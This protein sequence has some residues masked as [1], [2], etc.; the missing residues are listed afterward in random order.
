MIKIQQ[1]PG[2]DWEETN[3]IHSGS[4]G[5]LHLNP[6]YCFPLSEGLFQSPEFS[7]FAVGSLNY[8]CYLTPKTSNIFYLK[9]FF[10]LEYDCFPLLCWFLLYNSVSQLCGH[11]CPLFSS[12]PPTPH[13]TPLGRRGALSWAPCATQPPSASVC[14]THVVYMSMLVSRSVPPPRV[15]NCLCLHLYSRPANRL[16]NTIFLDPICMH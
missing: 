15:H 7:S 12:L 14:V 11:I 13:P 3:L 16:I 1:V 10:N 6:A 2:T 4:N 9:F 8:L 5:K